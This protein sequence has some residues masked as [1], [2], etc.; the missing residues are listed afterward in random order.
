[1]LTALTT[2]L[3]R[4]RPIVLI[5]LALTIFTIFLC[6]TRIYDR[7]P[8]SAQGFHPKSSPHPPSSTT[9]PPP[10]PAAKDPT[11]KTKDKTQKEQQ[12][13]QQ[14][15]QQKPLAPMSYGTTARPP[16]KGLTNIV[17]D[18]PADLLPDFSEDDGGE[19]AGA[20]PTS[21]KKRLIIIGDVHGQKTA[22]EALLA[23]V[24]FDR[25]ADHLI[26]TGDLINKG[27]D[28]AGVVSLAMSLGASAVR[29]NNEDRVLLAHSAM[30][31]SFISGTTG[32]D[33]AVSTGASS[34]ASGDGGKPGS[35]DG[36][37]TDTL[38]QDPFSHGDKADK[39]TAVSL[40]PSQMAWLASLPVMLRVGK[41]GAF[42]PSLLVVHAGLVPGVALDKQDPWAV[43]NMRSLK[44][45]LDDVLRDRVR[46]DLEHAAR[47]AAKKASSSSSASG[48]PGGKKP[49]PREPAPVTPE[50]VEREFARRKGEMEQAGGDP[51]E[52]VAVPVEGRDGEP[53]VDAWNRYQAELADPAARQTVVYG[54]DAKAGLRVAHGE[55]FTFGL[56]S[57]CV[58]GRELTAM[59]IEKGKK[60]VVGYHLQQV[61]CDKGTKD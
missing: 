26:L 39:D 9:P 41:V 48:S 53:W 17:A 59:I 12:Q 4:R 25:E 42:A 50:D 32:D 29:G 31:T 27:P 45:P 14:Q 38:E 49:P 16:I 47:E 58:Y 57:G 34:S 30:K 21:R 35:G 33:T 44:Y 43:M 46:A 54:H 20:V 61:K 10:P 8:L 28:S 51:R 56:D 18:L 3:R 23:K 5:A 7:M 15:Q 19:P 36:E 1:M 52:H 24:A 2:P 11:T 6:Y 37:P 22:L 40:T 55:T 13:Q 60:G